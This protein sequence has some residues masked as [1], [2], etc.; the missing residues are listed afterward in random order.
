MADLAR[1]STSVM[2]MRL[3]LPDAS[4]RGLDRCSK[5]SAGAISTAGLGFEDALASQESAAPSIPRSTLK[6]GETALVKSSSLYA[7]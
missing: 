2:Y 3:V 7:A 6:V 5:V 4:Y 1:S